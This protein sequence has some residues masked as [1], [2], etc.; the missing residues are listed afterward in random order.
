MT[1]SSVD[2][3]ETDRTKLGA[4][5]PTGD[6][7]HDVV[8]VAD[9]EEMGK[10]GSCGVLTVVI[11]VGDEGLLGG[12]EEAEGKDIVGGLAESLV[13]DEEVAHGMGLGHGGE[14]G[15]VGLK[16]ALAVED[17]FG[18]DNDRQWHCQQWIQ[19]RRRR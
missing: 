17:G 11:T 8:S 14:H 6:N 13:G 4:T 2:V 1:S 19:R 18:V 9:G 12:V 5:E 10:T 3:F 15:G 7:D 16:A